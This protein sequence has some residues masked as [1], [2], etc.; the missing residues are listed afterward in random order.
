MKPEKVTTSEVEAQISCA[1]QHPLPFHGMGTVEQQ[2]FFKPVARRDLMAAVNTVAKDLGLRASSV[3]VIDA[4]LSCLP[5]KDPKSGADNPITPQT[6]LTV[7]AANATLCFRAKGITD[8]QLRRHLER[9]EEIGLIRRKDSANGKRFPIQRN[10]RVVGAFGIDLSPLLEQSE[11]LCTLAETRRKEATELRGL[12]S[13]IQK[14][15]MDCQRLPLTEELSAFLDVT[16]N[17]MRRASTTLTQARALITKLTDILMNARSYVS[18]SAPAPSDQLEHSDE[19]VTPNH[20]EPTP[21]SH[22]TASDGQNDR[23]KEPPKSYTKKTPTAPF[24]QFWKSLVCLSQFY[25]D[26]PSSKNMVIQII[27]EFG[28]M[29]RVEQRTL[30]E[31]IAR[32]GYRETLIIQNRIADKAD[33]VIN[34]DAYFMSVIRCASKVGH[35]Q[36]PE[37]S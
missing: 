34:P 18:D 14:L 28:K 13:Y 24:S 1:L 25:P 4:L 10:G 35:G 30:A 16:R 22:L 23:H 9:L 15:R 8:R 11:K 6:L 27:F 20:E 19:E 3:M 32:I 31:A 36:L 26:T 21:T 2:P 29:L 37:F 12:R 7:Y 33:E 17:I 5:C